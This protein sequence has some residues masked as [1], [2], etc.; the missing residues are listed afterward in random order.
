M[1]S[2]FGLDAYSPH[3][4]AERVER[5]GSYKA[6][7][8]M[9]STFMLAVVGGGFIAL[10]AMFQ[11]V[12]VADPAL[13]HAAGRILGGIAF[14]M[15]YLLAITAGAEVFT[16]NHLVVMT[17]ASRQIRTLRLLRNWTLVLFGNAIGVFGLLIVLTLAQH[18]LTHGGGVGEYVLA[19]GQAKANEPFITALAKGIVGNLLIVTGVWVAMAGRSVTDR[20]L[21]PLLPIAALPIG[22][23][24]HTV[25]N[26]YYIPYAGLIQMLELLPASDFHISAF[27]AA[28]NL[29]AVI[30]GNIIGGGVMVALVFHLIYRRMTPYRQLESEMGDEQQGGGD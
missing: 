2:V 19:Q 21:G 13:N 9:A 29:V 7:L 14:A 16:T 8:P 26:L 5:Y 28:R 1:P 25:G 11:S 17:W 6:N 10:G 24:E 18:P 12:V 22:G 23:F 30:I 15:G 20:L 4:V 3:E 27:G